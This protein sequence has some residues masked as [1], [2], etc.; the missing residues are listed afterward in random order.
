[1]WVATLSYNFLSVPLT[2]A[3]LS[4]T[5]IFPSRKRQPPD[6]MTLP[7]SRLVRQLHRWVRRYE[8]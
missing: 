7:R 8:G 6:S 3:L 2:H 5:Q 1:M 4:I